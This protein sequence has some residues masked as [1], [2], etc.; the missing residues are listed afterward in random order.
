[1]LARASGELGPG[2]LL[3]LVVLG[4][5]RG[6]AA[7]DA[8]MRRWGIYAIAFRDFL[9]RLHV[10]TEGSRREID[11]PDWYKGEDLVRQRGL[12]FTLL[13][14]REGHVA[15]TLQP[16]SVPWVCLLDRGRLVH[17]EGDLGDVE[18]WDALVSAER[19]ASA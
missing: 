12:P 3:M 19:A 1:S 18:M 6:G 15:R 5:A 17:L 14:D 7:Y 2:Q 11:K 8:L 16:P 9:A 13:H 10:V 4:S